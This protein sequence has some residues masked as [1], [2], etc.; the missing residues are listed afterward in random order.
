MTASIET[1]N[2][3]HLHI[4]SLDVPWPANYGGAIDIYYKAKAFSDA[5]VQVHLHCFEYGRGEARNLDFCHQVHYYKRD[6]SFIRQITRI[7]YIVA[8]RKSEEL[9]ENLLK[10]DYPILC[11]GLHTTAIITDKR[12]SDRKIYVRA[13]NVEQDYYRLLAKAESVFWK[14]IY[15]NI[16]SYK[17]RSYED[18][19]RAASAIFA[20]SKKDSQY[21]SSKYKNVQWIPAFSGFAGV[22]SLPGRGSYV[23]YHGN[24]SVRE[25]EEAA[26]WLIRNVF[27]KV[28]VPCIIAG[29]N[30]SK[31]LVHKASLLS[32][33]SIRANLSESE[34]SELIQNAHVNVLVTNQPTG[35]KLKLLN[36]L[37]QGRFCLVNTDMLA[38]T[39]LEDACVIADKSEQLISEI[40]RL[41][42]EDFTRDDIEKRQRILSSMYN[43]AINAENMAN[44]IFT[45]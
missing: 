16:E 18:V 27:S 13:H 25:N 19:L 39:S 7:P 12:F 33:V 24:L 23:L 45:C 21:F 26:F 34:M 29:L 43:N 22:Q 11:E 28:S 40:N 20:I 30:P 17:L 44:A 32:N 1:M 15:F 37:S 42:T 6:T 31:Q 36:A 35:L 14:K 5:G 9:V 2:E 3:K 38:G 4:I 41:M 8:S 10:D